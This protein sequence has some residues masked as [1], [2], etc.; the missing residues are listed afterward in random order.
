M[1]K[2]GLFYVCGAF[3]DLVLFV[4]FE[5]HEKHHWRSVTF[6]NGGVLLLLKLQGLEL[7]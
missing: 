7:Y 1:N 2:S 5:K 6:I 3:R 4:Q